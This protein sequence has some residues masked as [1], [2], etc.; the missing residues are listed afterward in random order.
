MKG[1]GWSHYARARSRFLEDALWC[2]AVGKKILQ[3]ILLQAAFSNPDFISLI[4]NVFR[5]PQ[6]C[7]STVQRDRGQF[8]C[9]T[10]CG[11]FHDSFRNDDVRNCNSLR[12]ARL[13]RDRDPSHYRSQTAWTQA[14]LLH[15]KKHL[16]EDLILNFIDSMTSFS[17][18]S[19]CFHMQVF[20][21]QKSL[22]IDAD[23]IV[24]SVSGP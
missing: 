4:Q 20:A 22:F 17:L 3:G 1:S 5:G 9:A 7:T 19:L 21:I 10:E 14:C 8:F 11:T 2:W 12:D 15:I 16:C 23:S 18:S 6:L 24:I 13:A